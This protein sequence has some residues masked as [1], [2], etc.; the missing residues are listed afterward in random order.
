MPLI[1][2]HGLAALMLVAVSAISSEAL[3]QDQGAAPAQDQGAAPAQD[4]GQ[5]QGQGPAPDEEVVKEKH[6]DWEII[7]AA[8][9]KDLCVIR[10]I[11]LN[12]EGKRVLEVRIRKLND[13]KTKEG[14]LIPAAIQITTPLGTLLRSGIKV[15]ID[16][17]EA[18]TGAY[19]VCV[20]SGCVVRDAMS[21]EYLARL[22]AGGKAKMTFALLQRGEITANISL[23]GFTKAFGAL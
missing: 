20:P 7:C 9:Q 11:G 15:Q 21:E 10:Q 22:R 1:A 19:E 6:G 8:N 2:K 18:T 17:G 4:Q 12:A 13:V 23:A 5:A 3:A 14:Q 16:S